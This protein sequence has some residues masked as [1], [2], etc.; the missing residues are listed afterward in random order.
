MHYETILTLIAIAGAA[1]IALICDVL[2]AR[3]AEL[4]KTLARLQAKPNGPTDGPRPG[5]PKRTARQ[6]Q[7][8]E[9]SAPQVPAALSN[10][11]P[12]SSPDL[13][14]R[15]SRSRAHPALSAWLVE[16]AKARAAEE[17][18]AQS[19]APGHG[20]SASGWAYQ[21]EPF[22]GI[23]VDAQLWA[24]LCQEPAA[25]SIP[26]PLSQ[27][28]PDSRFEL[29][30]GKAQRGMALRNSDLSVPAGMHGPAGLSPLLESRKLF[31]GLVLSIGVE[32]SGAMDPFI[33]GLL[34]AVDFGCRVRDDEFILICPDLQGREAQRH[35]SDVSERVWDYQLRALG[36]FSVLFSVGGVDVRR[37]N[38]ADAVASAQERMRET[39]RTRREPPAPRRKAG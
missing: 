30:Q 38:L 4:R 5:G 7:S 23:V 19:W 10:P 13:T 37:E 36:Q 29:I 14:P 2:R 1:V 33:A 22:D 8:S 18:T 24:S 3:N 15:R 27:P 31:T 11:E 25:P 9:C 12:G 26:R 16:R 39:R 21:H 32:A 20:S 6:P 34:R 28:R 35:V 17:E